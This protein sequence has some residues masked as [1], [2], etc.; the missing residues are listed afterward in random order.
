[1]ARKAPWPLTCAWDALRT[2]LGWGAIVGSVLATLGGIHLVGHFLAAAEKIGTVVEDIQV[3]VV[4]S[5]ISE[6]ALSVRVEVFIS[7]QCTRTTHYALVSSYTGGSAVYPLGNT[8]SGRGFSPPWRHSYD[9][10]F[11]LPSGLKSGNY[12]LAIRAVY[13]CVWLG[14]VMPWRLTDQVIVQ[15]VS[16]P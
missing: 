7:D 3:S 2:R 6:R 8:L 9:V 13:E 11:S 12:T 10:V 16:V 1:M 4:P 15:N 5:N 14:G